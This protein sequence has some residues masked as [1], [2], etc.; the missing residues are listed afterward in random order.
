ML[1]KSALKSK[2]GSSFASDAKKAVKEL[3]EQINQPHMDGVIF[4][5]SSGFDLG[6]LGECLNQTFPCPVIGCTT[7][8][9]LT[10]SGYHEGTLVGASLG[11][12]SDTGSLMLHSRLLSPLKKLTVE[13]FNA[14]A[15]SLE[16]KLVFSSTFNS[17]DMF[18]LLLVDGMS[19]QE[20]TTIAHLYKGFRGLP[21]VGGSAGDD[22]SFQNT[23]VYHNGQF[24]C[25]AAIFTL[26]E[27]TLPFI[28]FKTQ[29]FV[30]TD[31]KLVITEADP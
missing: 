13:D 11:G 4:F 25:D 6:Q 14:M 12:D 23:H 10:S 28:T 18:G 31:K 27:T 5:C 16:E 30:P 2:I 7:A 26:F 1:T 17:N 3:Y 21:I 19:M 20:E 15:S 8:G 9:E 24:H 22:L 29:H